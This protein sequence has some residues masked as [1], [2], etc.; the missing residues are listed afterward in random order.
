MTHTRLCVAVGLILAAPAA[1]VAEEITLT[2]YDPS[3]RGV[4]GEETT[5]E[6]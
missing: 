6:T 2:T 4:Y 1:V 3:P 5:S